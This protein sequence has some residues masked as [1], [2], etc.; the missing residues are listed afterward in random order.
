MSH[1][2]PKGTH[3]HEP[4]IS[5]TLYVLAAPHGLDHSVESVICIGRIWPRQ[6]TYCQFP[7]EY[8]FT[9][10]S[11]FTIEVVKGLA[12]A[13]VNETTIRQIRHLSASISTNQTTNEDGQLIRTKAQK[14]EP[15]L[16]LNQFITIL[17]RNNNAIS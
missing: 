14:P 9:D 5:L 1:P 7:L 4:P 6:V 10:S 12:L 3:R 13:R 16:I 8:P 17:N 2:Q 11:V 15:V